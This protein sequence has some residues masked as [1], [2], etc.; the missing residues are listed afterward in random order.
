M[1]GIFSGPK[2]DPETK[3]LRFQVQADAEK[4][5]IL[6]QRRTEQSR[7]SQVTGQRGASILTAAGLEGG[8]QL[9]S[10]LG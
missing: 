10:R 4:A 1:G 3:R 9:K 7:W 8:G 5:R 6:R 2:E